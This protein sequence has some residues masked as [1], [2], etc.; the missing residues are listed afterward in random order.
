VSETLHET[1]R[2]SFL[3]ILLTRGDGPLRSLLTRPFLTRCY[4]P[5]PR[6]S[7]LAPRIDFATRLG[8]SFPAA[9]DRK[10]E[11]DTVEPL[12]SL[13]NTHIHNRITSKMPAPPKQRKMAIVGSR[14]VG[15]HMQAVSFQLQ[16]LCGA[17]TTDTCWRRQVEYDGAIR[18][19]SLCR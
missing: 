19:R 9:V 18:R 13:V 16:Q 3:A 17:T 1:L 14:A 8:T 4:L 11:H 12:N 7:S 6:T 5:R 2:H 10:R 15:K